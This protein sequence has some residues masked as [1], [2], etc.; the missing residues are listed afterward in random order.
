MELSTCFLQ[1]MPL[2]SQNTLP[3]SKDIFLCELWC[4]EVS[5][6]DISHSALT[7]ALF[8]PYVSL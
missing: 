7:E 3:I 1:I 6:S 2:K 5:S 4:I 8:F